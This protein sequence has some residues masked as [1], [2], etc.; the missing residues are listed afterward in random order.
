M[1][2]APAKGTQDNVKF[3]FE[4]AQALAVILGI[5]TAVRT[6]AND[7]ADRKDK[8]ANAT[9]VA[10]EQA[11]SVRREL[12]RPFREKKLEIYLE[13]ASVVAHL[14]STP[15]IDK[16]ANESKFWELYWG[17]LAFFESSPIATKMIAFCGIYFG[18]GRCDPDMISLSTDAQDPKLLPDFK[19]RAHVEAIGIAK[20]A[21]AEIREEWDNLGKNASEK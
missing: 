5:V 21:S 12:G 8:E 17:R 7:A 6:Y 9:R 3:W 13:T 15:E 1:V 19:K 10:N 4:C 14:A 2:W 18:Q 20:Q 11:E 16:D